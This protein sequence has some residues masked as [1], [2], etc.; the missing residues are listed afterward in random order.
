MELT[1]LLLDYVQIGPPLFTRSRTR[2][3]F[4]MLVS[5]LLHLE[6]LDKEMIQ[7]YDYNI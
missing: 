3:G 7:I 2:L 5:D 6:R 4:S 1:V